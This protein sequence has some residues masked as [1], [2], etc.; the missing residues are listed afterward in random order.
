MLGSYAT[1]AWLGRFIGDKKEMS[2]HHW[3]G[4]KDLILVAGHAVYI[5][6][7]FNDPAADANWLLQDF[8][9]GEPPFFIE[10]I[11]RGV[12]LASGNQN[13][14]LIFSGGQTR[15]EAG[16][17]SEAQ[18][19]WMIAKHFLWWHGAG[20]ELRATTEEFARDS[21]ENLLFGI[22]RFHECV[23][24]YPESIT[25]ISW[26]FKEKRFD[27]H[28]DAI[29]FPKSKFV[30]EGVN[31][32]VDLIGANKGEEKAVAQY[33]EDSFGIGGS[34][35]RKRDERNPFNRMNPY[36][37]SNPALGGLLRFRG[38]TNYKE[39]LPWV[40]RLYERHAA[41]YE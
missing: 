39:T 12:E 37:T 30:F 35:G 26:A 31:D 1:E 6:E 41:D 23:A 33:R 38:E 9:K 28:R 8:Q 22:C 18:S 5:A 15:R 14:L 20:V 11:F 34:L 24:S 36:K 7:D 2:N 17:R 27:L 3:R 29:G 25:V 40:D 13:S 4:L 16:P 19:Y 32:A 10:H 21:F